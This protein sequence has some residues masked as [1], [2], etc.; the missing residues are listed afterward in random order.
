MIC[1]IHSNKYLKCIIVLYMYSTFNCQ[2]Y[3][4][5]YILNVLKLQICKQLHEI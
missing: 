5:N 2:I 1:Y 4:I 3:I